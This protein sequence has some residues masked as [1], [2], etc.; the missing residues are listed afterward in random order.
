MQSDIFL[1]EQQIKQFTKRNEEESTRV[2]SIQLEI[3]K[4]VIK[5]QSMRGEVK[6]L[7]EELE[8]KKN[9]AGRNKAKLND[10]NSAQSQLEESIRT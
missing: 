9:V 8:D 2:S 1:R 4:Y 10:L 5:N 7:E 3:D 6:E